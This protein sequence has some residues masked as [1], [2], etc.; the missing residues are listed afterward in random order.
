MVAKRT[1][2]GAGGWLRNN[3]ADALH[4]GM[5]KPACC[6]DHDMNPRLTNEEARV[7]VHRLGN[8]PICHSSLQHTMPLQLERR[9]LRSTLDNSRQL[10]QLVIQLK[11]VRTNVRTAGDEQGS[12]QL[13]YYCYA[14]RPVYQWDIPLM[15]H[16]MCRS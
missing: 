14:H 10:L 6:A 7:F 12:L 13:N 9:V 16:S 4:L 15:M 11:L 1:N 5:R 2:A 3:F 8:L